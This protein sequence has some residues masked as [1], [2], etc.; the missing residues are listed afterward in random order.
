MKNT[1]ICTL[2][3]LV[4][5]NSCNF[6][7]SSNNSPNN[8]EKIYNGIRKNYLKGKLASTVT[9]KD[10]L[11]NGPAINYYPNGK[12]NMEFNY[13]NNKKDGEYKWYY[14]NGNVYLEGN[15][16][17]GEKNGT[18]N[19]YRENGTLKSKMPWYNGNPCVGLKE[20][21][22]SGKLKPTP[23]I[24]VNQ[25]NTIKLNGQCK[26]DFKFSNKSKT[27]KFYEENLDENSSFHAYFSPMPG[28][29]GKAS[30]TIKVLKGT[31]TMR[32]LSIVASQ[33]TADKNYYIVEKKI[34]IS[35][36]NR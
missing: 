36:E 3:S 7:E 35:L 14:E 17:Q 18:F 22:P 31:Y 33:K 8:S 24:I 32:T 13:K 2:L 29:K 15:Y 10:S 4:I 25:I 20:Y 16:T 30:L 6:I 11:K 21:S 27:V 9:Y 19:I 23:K 34:N 26:F 5:L 12:V 28:S 1:Y